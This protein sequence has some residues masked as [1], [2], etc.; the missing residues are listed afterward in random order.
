MSLHGRGLWSRSVGE[1]ARLMSVGEFAWLM[2]VV[3]VCG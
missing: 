2:S 3:D 1:F